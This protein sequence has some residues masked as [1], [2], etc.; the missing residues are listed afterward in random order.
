MV[1]LLASGSTIEIYDNNLFKLI[2]PLIT[3]CSL[4]NLFLLPILDEEFIKGE[5]IFTKLDLIQIS[6]I[7]KD[8]CLGII[9]LM[10]PD[11]KPLTIVS[12]NEQNANNI[13]IRIK[14]IY[15]T[16]LFQV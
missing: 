7:L 11:A 8:I 5:A 16:H 2:P 14:A 10:H 1:Q 3:F 6:S 9:H 13:D 4:Y 15:F 12:N